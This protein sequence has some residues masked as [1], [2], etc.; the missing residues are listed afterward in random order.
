MPSRNRSG[1]ST[2]DILKG[3]HK[4]RLHFSG[5]LIGTDDF[6]QLGGVAARNTFQLVHR[7]RGRIAGNAAFSTA[8]R[9]VD[10][11]TLPRHPKRQGGDLVERH[12]GMVPDAALCRSARKTE[13]NA[14]ARIDFELAGVALKWNRKDDLSRRIGQDPAHSAIEFEQV[15]CIVE[16]GDGVSENRDLT[17]GS[18]HMVMCAS[19]LLTWAPRYSLPVRR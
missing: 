6:D 14:I 8:E 1:S 4:S 11:G 16:I 19:G 17:N 9:K 5:V 15:G 3:R 12:A 7:Q 13:L 2:S 18:A 10:D